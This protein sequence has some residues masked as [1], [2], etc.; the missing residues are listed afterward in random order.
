MIDINTI[1]VTELINIISDYNIRIFAPY[2]GEFE[3]SVTSG[4]GIG[5]TISELMFS[6]KTYNAE[7]KSNNLLELLNLTI[8]NIENIQIRHTIQKHNFTNIS[9]NEFVDWLVKYKISIYTPFKNHPDWACNS[10]VCGPA[11]AG[12]FGSRSVSLFDTLQSEF[13]IIGTY[14][15]PKYCANLQNYTIDK[16]WHKSFVGTI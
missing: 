14:V 2:H 4:N 13:D 1:S 3:W 9:V 5:L 12:L 15:E 7:N 16:M 11:N 6:T 10:R 8:N